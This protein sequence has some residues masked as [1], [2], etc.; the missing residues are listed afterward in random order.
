[1]N[2][3]KEETRALQEQVRDLER[4]NRLYS[5]AIGQA[6]RIRRQWSE[7]MD[8]LKRTSRELE[9]ANAE[10]SVLYN[11]ATTL[12]ETLE[13]EQLL[14][15]I[16]ELMVELIET[17]AGC[18]IFLV[19]GGD[20]ELAVS[21]GASRPFLDA[22]EGM[23]VGD[24]LCGRVAQNGEMIITESCNGDP[25]HTIRYPGFKPHGHLILPL[26]AK[27]RVVGVFYYYLPQGSP[28]P[29]RKLNLFHAI[30]AQL[31][32][33]IENARLYEKTL[34]ESVHDALTGLFNRRYL[35]M[36]LKREWAAV[37]R[38]D[39]SL[40]VVMLDVDHFKDYNDT[41]GHPAGD[42]LL[43]QIAGIVRQCIRGADLPARYGGEEFLVLLRNTELLRAAE[44][45]ERLR[46]RIEKQIGIT[47]SFGAASIREGDTDPWQIITRAD[48]ALY[49]A[50]QKGRNRVCTQEMA[51]TE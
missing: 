30:G 6:E 33:A 15:R 50:K 39:E 49:A 38:T 1:M 16:I 11:V 24:C 31:G 23:R 7:A 35:E 29:Q 46:K 5:E 17:P 27:G 8:T 9:A 32:M 37:Q 42:R 10:L 47:A 34:A 4:Q 26:K 36:N 45:A 48:N 20:M 22:H 51:R 2:A 43:V 3:A 41:Y 21:R 25:R 28:M 44:V 14:D 18:G 12:S 13:L 40:S 19:N